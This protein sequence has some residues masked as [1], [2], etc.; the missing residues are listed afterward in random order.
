MK[1]VQI[2]ARRQKTIVVPF[3]REIQPW[4]ELQPL[5]P[6]YAGVE[7]RPWQRLPAVPQE[8]GEKEGE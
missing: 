2:A 5:P 3:E 8:T 6:I 4:G 1:V 7:V